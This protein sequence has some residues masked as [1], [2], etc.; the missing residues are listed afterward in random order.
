METSFGRNPNRMLRAVQICPTPAVASDADGRFLRIAIADPSPAVGRRDEG[1]SDWRSLFRG[2]VDTYVPLPAA[3]EVRI[4]EGMRMVSQFDATRAHVIGW[5]GND[6]RCEVSYIAGDPDPLCKCTAI[7]RAAAVAVLEGIVDVQSSPM[8]FAKHLQYV[9][10]SHPNAHCVNATAVYAPPGFPASVTVP[11]CGIWKETASRSARTPGR[12][13]GRTSLAEPDR[14]DDGRRRSFAVMFLPAVAPQTETPFITSP[15]RLRLVTT[16]PNVLLRARQVFFLD[17]L[18][19]GRTALTYYFHVKLPK[20]HFIAGAEVI[21]VMRTVVLGLTRFFQG[22]LPLAL[23]DASDGQHLAAAL[24]AKKPTPQVLPRVIVRT[25]IEKHAALVELCDKYPMFEELMTAI[26]A[27]K[28]QKAGAV[29]SPMA[30]LTPMEAKRIGRSLSVSMAMCADCSLAVC[31]WLLQ[32]S[33]L[34]ELQTAHPWFQA[35]MVALTQGLYLE[36]PWGMKFSIG[37]S[38]FLTYGDLAS[39]LFSYFLLS[40]RGQVFFADATAGTLGAS[41]GM[42]LLV[43]WVQNHRKPSSMLREGGLV[44]IGMKPVADTRK[45]VLGR[46]R[47]AHQL[48]HPL[49][50]LWISKC[51]ELVFESGPGAFFAV[52]AYFDA[53]HDRTMLQWIPIAFS[54]ITLGYIAAAIASDVDADPRNRVFDPAFYGYLPNRTRWRVVVLCAMT[55]AAGCKMLCVVLAT[56]LLI[57]SKGK[58]AAGILWAVRIALGLILK[59]LQRD[60]YSHLPTQGAFATTIAVFV[61]RVGSMIVC[62][63]PASDCLRRRCSICLLFRAGSISAI[64]AFCGTHSGKE[65]YYGGSGL[66]GH[67]SSSPQVLC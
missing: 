67:G 54:A 66:S 33:A 25:W 56:V 53:V 38:L 29:A 44:L 13:P 11:M 5:G 61:T 59:G 50:E 3:E 31:E 16:R 24:L 14:E 35:M 12:T 64:S 63:T 2:A 60:V 48:W 45:V 18:D 32:F 41:I 49:A 27:N 58:S 8:A 52:W 6:A 51:C 55:M 37:F 65:R 39:D 21:K 62:A 10:V 42:Q 47:D 40:S 7:V 34:Q 19:A 20:L 22:Q 28:L 46:K 4:A 43:T 15:R 17:E 1:N 30:L 23:L 26:R 57:V 36:V 9:G